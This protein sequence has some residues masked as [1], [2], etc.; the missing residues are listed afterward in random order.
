MTLSVQAESPPFYQDD[1][2]AIRIGKTRVLL[3]L[4]I[5]AFQDGA[6]PETIV[7]E[8]TSLNLSD[9]Y[10]TIAYYLRHQKEVEE[11]L[12]QREQRAEQAK[13]LV[14]R[15]QGDLGDI[16]KRLLARRKG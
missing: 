13:E 1:S 11:Y 5:D 7:Q 4:V 3:E 6:T 8:Y 10:A 16:R 15:Y 12:A 9:V 14:A 2:G